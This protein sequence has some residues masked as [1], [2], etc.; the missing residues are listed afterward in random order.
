MKKYISIFLIS[1]LW[2]TSCKVDD[3]LQD[4]N[5][6]SLDQLDADLLLNGIQ[7]NVDDFFTG[8]SEEEMSAERMI[9]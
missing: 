5:N 3:V 7:Q 2:F 1:A 6:P 9:S 8:I 4:P